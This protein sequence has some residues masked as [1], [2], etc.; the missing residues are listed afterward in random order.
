MASSVARRTTK[1]G[2]RRR[3][4][5]RASDRSPARR[6]AIPALALAAAGGAAYWLQP[7]PVPEPEPTAGKLRASPPKRRRP[8]D[9]R[10]LEPL[11]EEDQNEDPESDAPEA[12]AEPIAPPPAAAGPYGGPGHYIDVYGGKSGRLSPHSAPLGADV[13]AEARSRD[14]VPVLVAWLPSPRVQSGEAL[15]LRARLFG[16]DDE[17]VEPTSMEV[18]IAPEGNSEN[19]VESGPLAPASTGHGAWEYETTAPNVQPTPDQ[20]G[21]ARFRYVI[22]ARGRYAGEGFVRTAVGMFQLHAPGAR[23]DP[24]DSSVTR[25]GGDLVLQL[26][27]DVERAGAYWAYAELWGSASG[28]EPIAFGRQRFDRLEAGRQRVELLF[29]GQIIRDSGIDGPYTVRNLKLMQVDTLPPHEQD[30][31]LELAPTPGWRSTDFH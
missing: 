5:T 19:V 23:I 11:E 2:A 21:V 3:E 7:A 20:P 22:E 15:V 12:K 27:V 8:A 30:P 31:I 16:R 9:V 1:P 28:D 26:D 14:G 24:E 17:A 6:W 18:R 4:E 13:V 29:G 25:R 10:S